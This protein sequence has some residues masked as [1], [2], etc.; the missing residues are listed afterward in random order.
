MKAKSLQV[1]KSI[2]LLKDAR[3]YQLILLCLYHLI[4]KEFFYY[5]R[6]YTQIFTVLG[7]ALSLDVA[8]RYYKTKKFVPPLSAGILALAVLMI[9][10]TQR[11]WIYLIAVSIG[12]LSKAFI[13]VDRK[14]YFNPANLALVCSF[15]VWGDQVAGNADI[16]TGNVATITFFYAAGL[17]ICFYAKQ[18]ATTLSYMLGYTLIS[19]GALFFNPTLGVSL[20]A[21]FASPAFIIFSFQMISDPSTSPRSHKDKIAWGL[22]IAAIDMLLKALLIPFGNIYALFLLNFYRFLKNVPMNKKLIPSTVAAM[23][24]CLGGYRFYQ[25]THSDLNYGSNAAEYGGQR[26][27][28]DETKRLAGDTFYHGPKVPKDMLRPFKYVFKAPGVAVAD[29]NQDGFQDF[30]IL[31]GRK[32]LRHRLFLNQGGRRFEDKATQWGMGPLKDNFY[33]RSSTPVDIDGDLDIDLVITGD[34]CP[35]VFINEGDY[36]SRKDDLFECIHMTALVPFDFNKDGKVDFYSV[37]LYREGVDFKAGKKNVAHLFPENWNDANNGGKNLVLLNDGNGKFNSDNSFSRSI[38]SSTRFTID[39]GIY[40]IDG[41]GVVEVVDANDWG[42]DLIYKIRKDH[43]ELQNIKVN[44][45]KNGMNV[46]FAESDHSQKHSFYITNVYKRFRKEDGNDLYVFNGDKVKEQAREKG[47]YNCGWSWGASFGDYN[48]DGREDLYVTNGMITNRD[49]KVSDNYLKFL[50]SN[51]NFN[52]KGFSFLKYNALLFSLQLKE[53]TSGFGR[54]TT[55]YERMRRVPVEKHNFNGWQSDCLFLDSKVGFK[56]K[57]FESGLNVIAD[58]RAVANIDFDNDG[59]LDLIVTTQNKGVH[60]YRSTVNDNKDKYWVGFDLG[61]DINK[62]V[63]WRI[64]ITSG[65]N[66]VKSKWVAGGKSGLS[67]FSDPRVHFGL[68]GDRDYGLILQSPN[69]KSK[70]MK[71]IELNQYHSIERLVQKSLPGLLAQ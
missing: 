15:L 69:G 59:D 1:D 9:A 6:T 53:G 35:V 61:R 40:D 22:G 16:F 64:S 20:L 17:G 13:T 68:T 43:L 66:I 23:F 54:S 33:Y 21:L 11:T 57:Y 4:A 32:S 42:N 71:K 29:F 46:S 34:D 51:Y 49:M 50:G 5:T 56:N 58:G 37:R 70:L 8:I 30:F 24:V 41:D 18:L 19:V 52:F 3:L 26:I 44:D 55:G 36:F 62:F 60:F 7:F 39:S 38:A 14:H 67:A 28:V 63:G 27:F 48:L 65:D 12:V 47:V 2:S 10:G 45:T 25:Y 31:E